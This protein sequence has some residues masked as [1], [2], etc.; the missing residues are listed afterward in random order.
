MAKDGITPPTKGVRTRFF[1]KDFDVPRTEIREVE[2]EMVKIL[3]EIK[4]NKKGDYSESK[5]QITGGRYEGVEGDGEEGDS[6]DE[7]KITLP[8]K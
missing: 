1:R 5:S 8:G 2:D 7:L 3:N 4:E 6:T